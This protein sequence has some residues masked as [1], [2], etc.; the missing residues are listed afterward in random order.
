[1]SGTTAQRLQVS[2]SQLQHVLRARVCVGVCCKGG[3]GLLNVGVH[4]QL[5]PP[6]YFCYPPPPLQNGCQKGVWSG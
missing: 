2:I 3:A 4:L 6:E 1:M 5:A